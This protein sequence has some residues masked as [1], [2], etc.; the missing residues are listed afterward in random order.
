MINNTIKEIKELS[1]TEVTSNELLNMNVFNE[2]DMQILQI[3]SEVAYKV[4]T[5][6]NRAKMLKLEIDAEIEEFETR[7][8]EEIAEATSMDLTTLKHGI[9]V[10]G[11]EGEGST[12]SV[13]K[14]TSSL[15]LK[16]MMKSFEFDVERCDEFEDIDVGDFFLRTYRVDKDK[17]MKIN[18]VFSELES[19]IPYLVLW[20]RELESL[21]SDMQIR[22]MQINFELGDLDDEIKQLRQRIHDIRSASFLAGNVVDFNDKKTRRIYYRSRKFEF[23]DQVRLL[24]LSPTGKTCTFEAI[25]LEKGFQSTYY[26][27]LH[28][29]KYTKTFERVRV[30]T[31]LNNFYEMK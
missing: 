15:E 11:Y 29:T 25:T 13:R 1:G 6:Q 5:R 14:Y 8:F 19:L 7:W 31:L 18:I 22:V 28:K 27:P 21:Q 10:Y 4:E 26:I 17:L 2:F 20:N 16:Y 30:S 23:I 3:Q 24:K 9:H 12:F